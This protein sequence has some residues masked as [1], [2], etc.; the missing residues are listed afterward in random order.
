[1]NR[2]RRFIANGFV[3][4]IRAGNKEQYNLA[5]LHKEQLSGA[6]NYMRYT[7]EISVDDYFRLNKLISLLNVKYLI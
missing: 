3:S 2:K 6:I 5:E 1:M 4:I 7:E